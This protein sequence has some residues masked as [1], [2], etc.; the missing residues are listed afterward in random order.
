MK[1]KAK[2]PGGKSGIRLQFILEGAFSEG[3][4]GAFLFWG[5]YRKAIDRLKNS[6]AQK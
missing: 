5:Q 1:G 4:E 6:E 2:S 3:R